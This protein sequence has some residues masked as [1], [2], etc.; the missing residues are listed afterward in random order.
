MR[1]VAGMKPC[2]GIPRERAV[3]WAAPVKDRSQGSS[4]YPR[5][6]RRARCNP[7]APCTCR[8]RPAVVGLGGV[9][10]NS[11]HVSGDLR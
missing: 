3:R 9:Q 1:S 2:R 8:R 11:R 10:N 6:N 7:S 5:T 4:S